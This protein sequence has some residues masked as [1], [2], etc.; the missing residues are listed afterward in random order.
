MDFPVT[1][2]SQDAFDALVKDRISRERAKFADYDDLKRAAQ[3]AADAKTQAD[4]ALADA[5]ARAETAEGKVRG[6]ETEKQLAAWRDEV[7]K[8]TSIPAS[9]LRGSTKEE[10]EAHA[11]ELKPLITGAGPVIPTQGDEP[12]SHA[13][14]DERSFVRSL[15]GGGDSD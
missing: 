6:F 3:Q 5:L 2:D 14:S 13:T 4:Q 15:F 8:A 9:V 12:A 7:A 1:I 10:L 11:A